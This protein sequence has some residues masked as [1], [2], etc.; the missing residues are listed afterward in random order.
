[1]R[2][3][4]SSAK[5]SCQISGLCILL[6]VHFAVCMK[7][8]VQNLVSGDRKW[9]TDTSTCVLAL[10]VVLSLFTSVEMKD[11]TETEDNTAVNVQKNV[12]LE[13]LNM[14]RNVC[15]HQFNLNKNVKN[16]KII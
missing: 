12:H 11:W 4:K 8:Y 3:P 6:Q 1:M 2:V 13:C 7:N 9:E 15:L 14:F 5:F 10:N 16:I